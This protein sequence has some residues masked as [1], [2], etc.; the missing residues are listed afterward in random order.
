M[1][2]INPDYSTSDFKKATANLLPPGDYWSYQAGDPLDDLLTGLAI[3]FKNT[4]D[5]TQQNIL[6]RA[7]NIQA[8]WKL[9][10]YQTLLNSHNITGY[11]FDNSATPNLIYINVEPSQ[12]VGGLMEKVE[13]YRLPHTAFSW[14]LKNKKKL[15]VGAAHIGVKV[16]RKK[17]V[18]S[19]SELTHGHVLSVGVGHQGLQVHRRKIVAQ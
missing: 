9:V 19:N 11:V 5:D 6:Y 4:H 12:L 2:L 1:A 16:S 7:D 14:T 15:H 18:A 17:S 13:D 3:D 8:G 10:D